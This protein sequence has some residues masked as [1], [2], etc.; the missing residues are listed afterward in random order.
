[1]A[2]AGR[3]GLDIECEADVISSLFSEELGAVVQVAWEDVDRVVATFAEEGI[4]AR[5]I[6][7]TSQ[8]NTIEILSGGKVI[9]SN[10]RTTLHKIWS[11]TSFHIASLRDNPE[12]AQQEFALL[13]DP[14]RPGLFVDVP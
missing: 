14:N 13:D 5:K 6:G 10:A 4:L 11:E 8:K 7:T 9:Y 1:M 12:S 2:F 3:C